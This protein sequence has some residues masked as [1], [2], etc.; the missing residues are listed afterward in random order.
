[1]QYLCNWSI[2]SIYVWDQ[3]ID[4]L[5]DRSIV[6]EDDTDVLKYIDILCQS[7]KYI[8]CNRS[9]GWDR[10]IILIDWLIQ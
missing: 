7:I 5:I 6:I 2:Q 4:L 3:L 9:I 10:S 8:C 1:M